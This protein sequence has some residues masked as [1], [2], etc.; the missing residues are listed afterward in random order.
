MIA[1]LLAAIVLFGWFLHAPLP[2]ERTGRDGVRTRTGEPNWL[3]AR[4]AE[5]ERTVWAKEKLAESCGRIFDALWDQVNQAT[6]KLAALANFPFGELVL[7]DWRVAVKR[8]PHGIELRE[9]HGP[10]QVL[11]PFRW[12]QELASL[13]S[14]GW[15][16]DNLEFRQNQFD[17]GANGQPRRSD[18]YFAARLTNPDQVKRAMVEGSLGV[19][20]GLGGTGLPY[21]AK[22]LDA[23]KLQLRIRSGPPLF[24]GI[25]EE[26]FQPSSQSPYI[27]PLIVYDL[28]N[29]GVPEI[30]L[31]AKNLVYRRDAT[32][33]YRAGPLCR[34]PL[35]DITTAVV[36]DFDGDG[37]AD[38]LCAAARGLFLFVGD[39]SGSFAA[40]PRLVWAA[41]PPLKNAIVLTCG[42]VDNDGSLDVFLA[43]YRVPTLGQVLQPFYY[44]ANDG[45][46]AYLLLNDGHAHFRDATV[47]AGLG[48]KRWRRTYSAS[49][50]DLDSDGHLDL[51]V[52]S[53][54]AGLDLYR[55]DG[56]GKFT[57]VTQQWVAESH[58]FGMAHAL[59]D[60]NV[61]G[62]LDLL[63]IGM[64]S[65][66]VDR[67]QH[68]NLWRNYSAEDRSRRPDMVFGNRLYLA[69]TN[70]GFEQT[71]MNNSIARSGWS[72]GCGV[73]DFDNDGF[74]D[75]YIANGLESKQSVRDY[76]SEFWL[77]NL[78]IDETADELAVTRYLMGRLAKTRG[79]GWSYGGY[80]KNRLFLNQNGKDFVEVGHLAGVAL[81]QD[82]RN[83]VAQDLDGDG[84]P[85]LIVTTLQV[86]PQP[87]Q[88]LRIYQNTLADTG[89]WIGFRF[90]EEGRGKSP[91]G[92]RVM[93]HYA[94]RNAVAEITTGDGHRSQ[95]ATQ[96]HFGIGQA[97]T[98]D[99]AKIK[100]VD[101]AEMELR[102]PSIDQ[103]HVVRAPVPIAR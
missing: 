60:F 45:W 26:T 76:E 88:T 92:A 55:N 42:D 95:G 33:Q 14:Q 9:G 34:H 99:W 50:A 19:D 90:R 63:M 68:L 91:I 21:S 94:G 41:E 57:N 40:P 102:E 6:N 84:K 1:P 69:G 39:S 8:L 7:P 43:Q 81:E 22:R 61:D 77:H 86:W 30:L 66:T 24:R 71:A 65:P 27:D 98:L 75:V 52:V 70:G 5:A 29:D 78:F 101:G 53:D 89:H 59:A 56:H 17:T 54:F 28:D 97:T 13:A 25:F 3:E 67:L 96:V 37:R 46:P 48:A 47:S 87:K 12:R 49:L 20:W 85:D 35:D 58:A 51:A 93:I 18:F 2:W 100:W 32:K 79:S 38:L 64:P 62:R 103:W 15:R 4:E 23:S 73:F 82:C 16:L 74:P 83:V 11:F 80:E 36:A 72:W 31:P 10:G 44:D